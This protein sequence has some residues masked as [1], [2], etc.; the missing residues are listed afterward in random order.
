MLGVLSQ[1]HRGYAPFSMGA[2]AEIAKA[3]RARTRDGN[4]DSR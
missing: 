4:D 1:P 2:F 3:L